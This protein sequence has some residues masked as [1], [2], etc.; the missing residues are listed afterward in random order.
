[1]CLKKDQLPDT[2][3]QFLLCKLGL[4]NINLGQFLQ[5]YVWKTLLPTYTIYIYCYLCCLRMKPQF[6]T[7]MI[8]PISKTSGVVRLHNFYVCYLFEELCVSVYS[9]P[10][11]ILGT[12]DKI[13]GKTRQTQSNLDRLNYNGE[14]GGHLTQQQACKIYNLL[15]K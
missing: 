6:F 2:S 9:K 3:K 10:G 13:I 14:K 15:H 7:S 8:C 12:G 1:M 11:P 5:D 4:K